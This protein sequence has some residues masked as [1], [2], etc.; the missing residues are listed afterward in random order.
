MNRYSV[1]LAYTIVGDDLLDDPSTDY[2]ELLGVVKANSIR[3]AGVKIGGTI[4][5]TSSHFGKDSGFMRVSLELDG[6]TSLEA[7][8]VGEVS[9]S[10]LYIEGPIARLRTGDDLLN[11]LKKTGFTPK[12][13]SEKIIVGH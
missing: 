3:E 6:V 11:E 7:H 1:V 13:K 4:D 8:L 9:K 12:S 10:R 5:P 2:E